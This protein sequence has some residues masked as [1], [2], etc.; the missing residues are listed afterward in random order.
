MALSSHSVGAANSLVKCH[1][2]MTYAVSSRCVPISGPCTHRAD[3]NLYAWSQKR[4]MA[5]LLVFA[6]RAVNGL[7]SANPC[8]Q[9]ERC[10]PI[11]P[12]QISFVDDMSINC[13]FLSLFRIISDLEGEAVQT[14]Y[15][16]HID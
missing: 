16:A 4:V 9:I 12:P 10:E 7:P 6:E 1:S 3:G 11:H 14:I 8:L 2:A 15:H 13:E 5:K